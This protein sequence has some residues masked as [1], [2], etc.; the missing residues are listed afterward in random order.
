VRD[1][2]HEP[3]DARAD[4]FLTTVVTLDDDEHF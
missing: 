1:G 2:K 4:L 3:M